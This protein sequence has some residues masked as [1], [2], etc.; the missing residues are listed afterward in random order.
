MTARVE[1]SRKVKHRLG[2]HF[3]I[4]TLAIALVFLFPLAAR[5][6]DKD[7]QPVN[8]ME[9]NGNGGKTDVGTWFMTYNNHSM[10]SNNFGS[11]FAINYR[12][13]VAPDTYDVPESDDPDQIDFWLSMLAEAKVDFI[14][15]DLTNGGLTE[16]VPYGWSG[17]R[18][19]VDNAQLTSRR[20]AE[21]NKTHDW[22]LR[23]AVAV[24]T[25]A[26]LNAGKPDGMSAELQAEGVYHL[27]YENEEYGGENYYQ[28]EGKP[29]LLL[30][31]WGENDL[32]KWENYSGDKTY[33]ERFSVRASQAG[34][35]G[36]YGWQ[37]K[38]GVVPQ[39]EVE[40]ICPGFATAGNEPSIPRENGAY[41]KRSWETLLANPMPR[42]VMISAFNDFNEH[43]AVM[44]ALSDKCNDKQEEQ[45]R[46]ET[47]EL[48]P[49]MYWDMTVE[50][51]RQIRI[52]NGEME[53][54]P[55]APSKSGNEGI[56]WMI[57]IP[58]MA[59]C[60]IVLAVI[61]SMIVVVIRM[62]HPEKK[63]DKK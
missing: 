51:I 49:T 58:V 13:L 53:P 48:N 4:L 30:H 7:K 16:E 54:D 50:G 31:D 47:G 11:G 32:E 1:R 18:W 22:K 27:F 5:A 60:V 19:I 20:I 12:A 42:I 25:Y 3:I 63:D 55:A 52:I 10:W 62:K 56:N 26:A 8:K 24:G 29:L 15:Y 2:N 59:T 39:E 34:E 61:V 43:L 35:L 9:T 17:N 45:W 40:L 33:S 21:W 38:Y 46:D 6:E 44:P 28:I 36:T 41:Y 23:Y 14:V 57:V 37:T